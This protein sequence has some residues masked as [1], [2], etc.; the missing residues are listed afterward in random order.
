M[1]N[2]SNEEKLIIII[3]NLPEKDF[4]KF[5]NLDKSIALKLGY[6][7]EE[8]D[9]YQHIHKDTIQVYSKEEFM[10]I[11]KKIF[12]PDID[13]NIIDFSRIRTRI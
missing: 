8:S 11:A 6:I 1:N 2:L 7:P 12:G 3:K 10:N 4:I 5:E 9:A 13:L